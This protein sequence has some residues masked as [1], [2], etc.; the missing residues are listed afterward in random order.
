MS[1]RLEDLQK[2]VLLRDFESFLVRIE[3]NIARATGRISVTGGKAAIYQS[4][5]T[6]QDFPG[7][8]MDEGLR[9]VRLI[10][11]GQQPQ[12][13]QLDLQLEAV[14]ETTLDLVNE[15]ARLTL[16]EVPTPQGGQ[17]PG[18]LA[19][20]NWN[21]PYKPP[22]VTADGTPFRPRWFSFD[23]IGKRYCDALQEGRNNNGCSAL[24]VVCP[25]LNP[26]IMSRIFLNHGKEI[27][28]LQPFSIQLSS[29]EP[30]KYP[31]AT[32]PPIPGAVIGSVTAVQGAFKQLLLSELEELN[33]RWSGPG[34]LSNEKILL[35]LASWIG[36]QGRNLET[37]DDSRLNSVVPPSPD[38]PLEVL[39]LEG[40]NS[41]NW[42]APVH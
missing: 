38:S 3:F 33:I 8:L 18:W 13:T 6:N 25:M 11:N 17:A 32:P 28:D 26:P 30:W 31:P 9:W 19:A 15:T 36:S 10:D 34:S 14:A 39:L 1:Y 21:I 24:R 29:S 16:L 22:K 20:A 12:A 40:L 37:C 7:S 27:R 23:T 35:L 5:T 2:K 4:N 42:V 41:I